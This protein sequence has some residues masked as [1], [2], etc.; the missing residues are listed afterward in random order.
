MVCSGQTFILLSICNMLLTDVAIQM[1]DSSGQVQNLNVKAN[2]SIDT[3]IYLCW[4][5]MIVGTINAQE[6]WS[7]FGETLAINKFTQYNFG[8]IG[9][10]QNELAL[11]SASLI[12]EPN[13]AMWL[14]RAD[15]GVCGPLHGLVDNEQ[16]RDT[17]NKNPSYITKDVQT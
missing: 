7:T 4:N 8:P 6:S 14:G 5:F 17:I 11:G 3:N 1:G 9:F 12:I 10:V 2:S 13:Y 15:S 16:S